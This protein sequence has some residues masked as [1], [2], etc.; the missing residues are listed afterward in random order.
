MKTKEEILRLF[1]I[2]TR[3]IYITEEHAQ[4]LAD[5]FNEHGMACIECQGTHAFLTKS[6]KDAIELHVFEADEIYHLKVK[7][8]IIQR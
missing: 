5:S 6:S 4:L 8:I 3:Q 7:D 2:D 1:Q